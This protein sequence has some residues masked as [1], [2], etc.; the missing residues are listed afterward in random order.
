MPQVVL[1]IK[2]TLDKWGLVELQGSVDCPPNVKVQGA[3]IGDLHI[4]KSGT[5]QLVVG[6][7]ILSGKIQKLDKPFCVMTKSGDKCWVVNS[8]IEEKF[9]FKTRPKPIIQKK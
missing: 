5:P 2:D 3:H 1:K 4:D 8:I 7:H 9:I 6:H